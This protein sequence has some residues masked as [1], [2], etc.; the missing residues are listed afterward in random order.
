MKKTTKS[1]WNPPM[2]MK[3]FRGSNTI[4][5][6]RL[7]F[8]LVSSLVFVLLFILAAILVSTLVF[9]LVSIL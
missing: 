6:Y 3:L 4:E 2:M 7:F 9:V 1:M 5:Y 8:I